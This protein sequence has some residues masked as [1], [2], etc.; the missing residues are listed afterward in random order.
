VL[1]W[2]S[3]APIVGTEATY[4]WYQSVLER[5]EYLEMHQATEEIEVAGSWAFTWGLGSGVTIQRSSGERSEFRVKYL[6]VLRKQVNGSWAFYRVIMNF[7]DTCLI[8]G[9]VERSS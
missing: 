3:Q 1:L 2:P 4:S 9:P 7:L 5:L 8:S 6:H